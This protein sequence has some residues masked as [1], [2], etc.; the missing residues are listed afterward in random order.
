MSQKFAL[1][2]G[3]AGGIGR[4]MVSKYIA[5]GYIVIGLDLGAQEGCDGFLPLQIDL[6]R[7]VQDPAYL[8]QLKNSVQELTGTAGISVLINN[9]AVQ[10]L[11]TAQQLSL[12]DWLRTFDINLHA[13]FVLTKA[14]YQSLEGNRGSVINVSS[15]HAHLTKKTFA[16]YATSKA[17]LSALTRN[18]ALEFQD[19]VRINAIEPAAISTDMLKEGFEGKDEDYARLEAY[20][21]LGRIGTPEEVA[22]LAHFLSSEAASFLHGSCISLD[23]GISSCLSDPG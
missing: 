4:A 10:L 21:P 17:A 3:S 22:E 7:C 19:K 12:D 16:A 8:E 9:A 23:G 11:G 6:A 14:F 5:E 15:I 18:L 1:V 20:H 2:T 13:P